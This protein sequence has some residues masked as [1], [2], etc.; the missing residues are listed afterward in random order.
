MAG[1]SDADHEPRYG[2]LPQLP[3][4]MPNDRAI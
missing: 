3:Y 4:D 2:R 1:N